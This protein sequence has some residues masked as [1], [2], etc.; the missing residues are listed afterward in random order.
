MRCMALSRRYEK[1]RSCSVYVQKP[2]PL[3][4]VIPSEARRWRATAYR[5]RCQWPGRVGVNADAQIGRVVVRDW[6][7]SNLVAGVQDDADPARNDSFG[8]GDDQAGQAVTEALA[9][10][11][12]RVREMAAKVVAKHRVGA[13]FDAVTG[14][15]HDPVPRVRAAAERATVVLTAAQ[16]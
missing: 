1:K 14:L 8:E 12:W 16:S 10:E 15:R 2:P 13:A 11:H 5:S 6:I 9:D 3:T 4:R 7:A